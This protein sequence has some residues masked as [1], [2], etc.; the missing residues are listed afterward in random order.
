MRSAMKARPLSGFYHIDADYRNAFILMKLSNLL[1]FR[2]IRA[3]IASQS[4]FEDFIFLLSYC[5]LYLILH[6]FCGVF[7]C[8]ILRKVAYRCDIYLRQ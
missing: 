2:A 6:R 8:Y 4:T 1:R 7:A 5:Y 3:L